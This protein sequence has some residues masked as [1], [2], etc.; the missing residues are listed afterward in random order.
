M[1]NYIRLESLPVFSSVLKI[2]YGKFN[3]SFSAELSTI[4]NYV[5]VKN[6]LQVEIE[7]QAKKKKGNDRARVNYGKWQI[8]KW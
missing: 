4:Q 3:F 2:L 1:T 5:N 6:I 8:A 7:Q